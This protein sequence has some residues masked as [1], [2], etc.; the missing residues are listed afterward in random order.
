MK[1]EGQQK[2][3]HHFVSALE[4]SIC[5]KVSKVSLEEEWARTGPA[6]VRHLTLHQF[7]DKVNSNWSIQNPSLMLE[8]QFTGQTTTMAITIT[9][10][11][12]RNTTVNLVICPTLVHSWQEDGRHFCQ[13]K[14]CA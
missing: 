12:A 1:N 9:M 2:I 13:R 6:K 8:S 14:D 3:L 5:V 10:N 11:S 7:L 4:D